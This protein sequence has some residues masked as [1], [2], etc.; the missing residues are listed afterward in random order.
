M[1]IY[2]NKNQYLYLSGDDMIWK[3]NINDRVVDRKE[4]RLKMKIIN[5]LKCVF[6]GL[7]MWVRCGEY[8]PHI[9]KDTYEKA[10]IISSDTGFRVSTN[11]IHSGAETVHKDACLIRSKCIY[12]GKE[13][14]GWYS[15]YDEWMNGGG[16]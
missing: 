14:L 3:Y 13:S 10:I 2:S 6:Q 16:A 9:Y 11:F 8:I 5:K 7:K 12:C 1:L 15:N 4:R